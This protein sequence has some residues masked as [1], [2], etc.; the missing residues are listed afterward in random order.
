MQNKSNIS[1]I[2]TALLLNTAAGYSS[3]FDRKWNE[4][5][6]KYPPHNNLTSAQVDEILNR[7]R[8]GNKKLI[9]EARKKQLNVMLKKVDPRKSI[10]TDNNTE[11]KTKVLNRSN[12]NQLTELIQACLQPTQ[13]SFNE[14][15]KYQ[16]TQKL[17]NISTAQL[18]QGCSDFYAVSK[19]DVQSPDFIKASLQAFINVISIE[20]IEKV[21][22]DN[23]LL[24]LLDQ[25]FKDWMQLLNHQI[26]VQTIS[27]E[28]GLKNF[29]IKW[30]HVLLSTQRIL[31]ANYSLSQSMPLKQSVLL[32]NQNINVASSNIVQNNNLLQAKHTIER[33][34]NPTPDENFDQMIQTTAVNNAT[35]KNSADQI[36]TN[37]SFAAPAAISTLSSGI[38]IKDDKTNI[39]IEHNDI[40]KIAVFRPGER[41]F[42]ADLRD[43]ERLYEREKRSN[44]IVGG[45]ASVN[46]G[47]QQTESPHAEIQASEPAQ[48]NANKVEYHE[49]KSEAKGLERDRDFIPMNTSNS[50]ETNAREDR[51]THIEQNSQIKEE[52]NIV[53]E[54]RAVTQSE[55]GIANVKAKKGNHKKVVKSHKVSPNKIVRMNKKKANNKEILNTFDNINNLDNAILKKKK[56]SLQTNIDGEIVKDDDAQSRYQ[57]DQSISDTNAVEQFHEN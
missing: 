41:M 39:A 19:V 26:G 23:H 14:N 45:T 10:I 17:N 2:L 48:Q 51:D 55:N 40:N 8:N 54:S 34:T 57:M 37:V 3:S 47:I 30:S 29:I 1:I 46:S 25:K 56:S 49:A 9:P 44:P 38:S 20:N 18:A 36:E 35:I 24:P 11:N 27:D 5:M 42:H 7:M 31:K 22:S 13:T 28:G 53:N 12:R 6:K 15:E 43:K 4:Y 32:N 52:G 21:A 33:K 50:L 16:I